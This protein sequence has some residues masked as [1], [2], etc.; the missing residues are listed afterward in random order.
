MEMAMKIGSALLLGAFIIM[1][2]PQTRRMLAEQRE[3]GPG[4]WPSF[5]L[6]I[7]AVAGFIA[8]LMWLV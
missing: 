2:I 4:D 5:L 6:P 8:L 3:A 1:L 7:L